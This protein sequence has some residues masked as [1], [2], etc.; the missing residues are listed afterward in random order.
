[1]KIQLQEIQDF[2]QAILEIITTSNGEL[3]N[4]QFENLQNIRPQL[5]NRY[6]NFFNHFSALNNGIFE[7]LKI[8]KSSAIRDFRESQ[9]TLIEIIENIDDQIE[10]CNYFAS[11]AG[12]SENEFNS[13]FNKIKNIMNSN[14]SSK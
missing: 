6:R 7:G 14:K 2:T 1:M 10:T 13:Y 12:K 4:D 5:L 11:G 8:L 9:S 3:T